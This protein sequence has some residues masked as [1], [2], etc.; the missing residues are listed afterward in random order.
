M[1]AVTVAIDNGRIMATTDSGTFDT[2]WTW[3]L[4]NSYGQEWC[5]EMNRLL[6]R[7]EGTKRLQTI[8]ARIIETSKGAPWMHPRYQYVKAAI[9]LRMMIRE[10]EATA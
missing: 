9:T 10:R 6:A 3:K 2:G 1:T 7:Q 5:D 4:L 8:R